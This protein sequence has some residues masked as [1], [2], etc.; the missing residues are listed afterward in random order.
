M[1]DSKETQF[2]S[3]AFR[4]MKRLRLLRV[5]RDGLL[6]YGP[7]TVLL[8][9]NFEFPSHELRYLHWDGWSLDSLPSSFNGEKLVK[10]SLRDSSLKHLW[11]EN[12]VKV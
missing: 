11:K 4:K 7:N 6:P 10:L 3:E 9:K 5:H 1:S 8:P 2:M 12:K